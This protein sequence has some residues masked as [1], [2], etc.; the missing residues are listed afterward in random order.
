[1]SRRGLTLVEI[2]LAFFLLTL[3]ITTMVG[4]FI[5]GLQLNTQSQGY[6][7]ATEIARCQMEAIRDLR[8]FPDP[9]QYDGR[10]PAPTQDD[11]PPPPYPGVGEFRL[12]VSVEDQDKLKQVTVEAVWGDSRNVR[13]QTLVYPVAPAP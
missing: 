3:A 7:Q 6:V 12:V 9:G 2:C 1:L 13:L 8:E 11:F 4:L 5:S 10:I